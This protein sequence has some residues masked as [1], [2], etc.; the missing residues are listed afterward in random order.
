MTKE[1]GAALGL[2]AGYY[3]HHALAAATDTAMATDGDK[4]AAVDAAVADV[5]TSK[6]RE[7]D[8]R[9]TPGY[10][11]RTRTSHG[12]KER[13]QVPN[14]EVDKADEATA[15]PAISTKPAAAGSLKE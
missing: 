10:A 8:P 9:D 6:H 4:Q 15:K 13:I 1:S 14:H 11:F 12:I 7:T 2:G 5:D 3:E